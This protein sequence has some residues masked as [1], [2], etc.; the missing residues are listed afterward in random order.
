MKTVIARD[1]GRD[2]TSIILSEAARHGF[3]PIGFVAGAIGES[4]LNEHAARQAVWPDVSFGL[5]QP[6]VAFLGN[7]V[8]GLTRGPSGI[9]LDTPANRATARTFCFDAAKLAAYVAPRYA[10]L[11]SVHG[12]SIEAWCR[13]N[14]PSVP[15][16]SNP[17]RPHI[18]AS[19]AEAEQFRDS[20]V[21]SGAAPLDL[22]DLTFIG[23]HSENFN[24]GRGGIKPEAIVLHIA[25]GP[26]SAVDSWFNQPHGVLGPSSAHFCVAKDGRLH[27]YVNT[28]NT[29]FANGI[30][31]PG[32]TA[33]L[34]N[35]NAGINPNRWT[36]SIEHEG[37]SGDPVPPA[38]LDT[39]TRLT[40]WLFQNRLFNSG[41]TGVAVDRDHILRHAD[42]SPNS[43][44]H[45]PGWSEPF[46]ADY[47]AT[48]RSLLG[49]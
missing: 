29:A 41:A 10:Q 17:H 12:S 6:A 38:Q 34:V 27:Q 30:I 16:T 46:I 44:E 23:A 3:D 2:I 9:V 22:P 47:I 36:I 32:F 13:W 33:S 48:V 24:V 7:N 45:C 19:H 40:A 20:A 1:T 35:D 31:E 26:L 42:I 43:R 49:I 21:P 18:V 39:S 14:L 8:P 25:E 37:S 4:S 11:L 28:G 15:G 5:W